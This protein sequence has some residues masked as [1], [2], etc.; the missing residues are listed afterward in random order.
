MFSRRGEYFPPTRPHHGYLL[1]QF[2]ML[3]WR[4]EQR[5]RTGGASCHASPAP[6][7]DI[8]V[9]ASHT[10]SRHPRPFF[11]RPPALQSTPEEE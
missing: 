10:A 5:K 6:R 4:K 3:L 1:G 2:P 8:A 9:T 11:T 7:Q